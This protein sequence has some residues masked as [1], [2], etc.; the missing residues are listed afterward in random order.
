MK[1]GKA[2]WYFLCIVIFMVQPILTSVVGIFQYYDE[3]VVLLFFAGYLF[4]GKCDRFDRLLFLGALMLICVGLVGNH[5]SA[6]G[7]QYSAIL[8][9][10]F[11]N[12]KLLL[13][14]IAARRIGLTKKQQ[15]KLSDYI[16]TF[17]RCLFVIMFLTAVISLF[18]NI[19]MTTKERYGLPS[20]RF[21][22][23][24]PAGLNTYFYVYMIAFSIT[25]FKGGHLRKNTVLYLIIGIVPW[26][27]TLRSR[28][29][30]FALLYVVLFVYIVFIRRS[31]KKYRFRLYHVLI[32]GVA[33]AL[34]GWDSI[35]KYFISNDRV[36]RYQLMHNSF[37]LANDYF[38]FGS[39]FGTFGAQASRD[40]YSEIYYRYGMSRI[41][42]LN[43]EHPAF[44]TD[45]YWFGI[46]GQFGYLGLILV[47]LMIFK[48]YKEI[49]MGAKYEKSTQ[50][51][52]FTLFYTSIFASFTAGVFINASLLPSVL[53]FYLLRSDWRRGNTE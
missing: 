22:F 7:Q 44:I 25:M 40:Y 2:Q 19:G 4:K 30:A 5:L 50:L 17:V 37:V 41:Y 20:F 51:A 45:Q 6:S 46:L 15:E 34:L 9:D 29:I 36:S 26:I 47:A 3:I 31:G 48:I 42:G 21:L 38:P 11:S 32:I 8:Q 33:L 35:D 39:G 52:A 53:L 23:A 1:V 28:A 12:C 43:P 16:S 10:I 49:W 18:I 14:V 24:N 13:F 27:L